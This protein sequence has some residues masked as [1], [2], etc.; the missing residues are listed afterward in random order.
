[1]NANKRTPGSRSNLGSSLAATRSVDAVAIGAQIG[2]TLVNV[3][4]TR[5]AYQDRCHQRE[6]IL[7]AAIQQA[8]VWDAEATRRHDAFRS[9]LALAT[10]LAEGG[11]VEQA[12]EALSLGVALLPPIE[13]GPS[14][15]NALAKV[16]GM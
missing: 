13:A 14:L 12:L 4:N 6:V 8:H 10:R 15:L 1:M 11:N 7:S 16:E 2:T 9:T 3:I 5:T